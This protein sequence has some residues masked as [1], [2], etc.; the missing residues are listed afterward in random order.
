MSGSQLTCPKQVT[1][2]VSAA[3]AR[4]R[5]AAN[6]TPSSPPPPRLRRHSRT[7]LRELVTH[8]IV[9]Q[10]NQTTKLIIKTEVFLN[11]ATTRHKTAA[12]RLVTSPHC[13]RIHHSIVATAAARVV[14]ASLGPQQPPVWPQ[15]QVLGWPLPPHSGTTPHLALQY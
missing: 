2:P 3:A 8:H 12:E 14:E 6:H 4:P 1:C 13:D 15:W 5:A 11:F 7:G 10:C 9:M